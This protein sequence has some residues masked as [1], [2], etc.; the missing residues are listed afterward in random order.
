LIRRVL[1]DE[2]HLSNRQAAEL[3]LTVRRHCRSAGPRTVVPLHLSRQCNTTDLAL[4]AAVPAAG[5]RAWVVPALQ[6]VP[7]E[8][9]A[10][11]GR[12][13]GAALSRRRLVRVPQAGL[14]DDA[15]IG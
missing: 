8:T 1:S 10:L 6:D 14:F 7:T 15:A 4:A 11:S 5:E 2:G 9:L 12:T 3:L 13:A